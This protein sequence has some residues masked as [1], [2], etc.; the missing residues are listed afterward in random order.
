MPAEKGELG[1]S[2]PTHRACHPSQQ[3]YGAVQTPRA[4][5]IQRLTKLSQHVP[6][7]T[8]TFQP[9][10]EHRRYTQQRV[11]YTLRGAQTRLEK[12][13]GTC[14]ATFSTTELQEMQKHP[15]LASQHETQLGAGTNKTARRAAS[16]AN[17]TVRRCLESMDTY[18]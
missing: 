10:P 2:Q 1:E 18:Y 17:H 13:L 16:A 7:L 6:Q 15:R 5:R 14:C 12:H 4:A 9:A 8:H 11:L 3:P